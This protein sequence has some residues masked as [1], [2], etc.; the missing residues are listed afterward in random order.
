MLESIHIAFSIKMA[1]T[2]P[3]LCIQWN[4]KETKQDLTQLE[5]HSG[6]ILHMFMTNVH[7][8][9]HFLNPQ[10]VNIAQKL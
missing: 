10:K 3:K 4:F 6:K 1:S 7:E 8:E 5:F 9:R 2:T